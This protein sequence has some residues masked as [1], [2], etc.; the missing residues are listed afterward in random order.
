MYLNRSVYWGCVPVRAWRYS[1]G[2]YQVIKKWLSYRERQ[3]L[4]RDLRVEE[5]RHVRDMVRRIVELLL[6]AP[7]LD[8]N[9]LSF[10]TEPARIHEMQVPLWA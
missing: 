3:V 8:L 9:Y 2:G 1:L 5:V 6:L 10:N 7:D 4:G